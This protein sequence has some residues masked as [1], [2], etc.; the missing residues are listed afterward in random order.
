MLQNKAN[1]ALVCG[2]VGVA[3]RI[4]QIIYAWI[5]HLIYLKCFRDRQRALVI[6]YLE[7]AGADQPDAKG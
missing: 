7:G 1:L 6:D 5:F 2:G 3:K 4:P